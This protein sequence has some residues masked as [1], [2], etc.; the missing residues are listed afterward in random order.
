MVDASA[1]QK[2]IGC[3]WIFKK[4]IEM[5]QANKIRFKARLVAKGYNQKEGIDFNEV[6]S[7]V[8]KHSS[9]R[10]LLAVVVHR[11]WELHQMD[12]KTTFLHGELEETIVM[13]QP[14]GFEVKGSEDKVCLL[15]RSIYG[16]KQS[17]WQWY[18]KF[19]THM[20]DIGFKKS[21]YDGCVYIKYNSEGVGIAYLVLY[22]DDMLV[23]A[24]NLKE[25]QNV[26]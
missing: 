1:Y 16:L 26:K 23:A 11:G 8:V 12:V 19:D 7:P 21:A 22:V 6:F 15:K 2:A 5:T 13:V 17:S 25:I 24:E 10:I 14:E 4:K 18:R 20:S 3:K 9:I